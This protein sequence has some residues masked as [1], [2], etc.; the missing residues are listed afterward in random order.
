MIN[1]RRILQLAVVIGI[2]ALLVWRYGFDLRPPRSSGMGM[3]VTRTA[4]GFYSGTIQVDEVQVSTEYGGR[5]AEVIV[6]EG[7]AVRQG[8]VLAR[9]DTTLIDDQIA[10]AEAQLAVALAGLSQLQAGA[11]PGAVAIAEA[12]KA[13][14]EATRDAARQALADAQ[15]VQA[16]PQGLALQAT[17]ARAQLAAA[18]ARVEQAAAMRDAA[19][20]GVDEQGN[21]L[22]ISY[23][24]G[25]ASLPPLEV[26]LGSPE[27]YY[28]KSWA[29]VNGAAAARDGLREQVAQLEAQ[30]ADPQGPVARTHLAEAELARAEAAVAVAEAQVAGLKA[31]A[32]AEELAAVQARV[33]QA[34][35]ALDALKLQRE[36]MALTAP[37][38]G[39]VLARLA[40]PGEVAAPGAS[41]ITLGGLQQ[42]TLAVYVPESELGHVRP[43]QAARVTVDSFPGRVFDG[44]VLRIA[45][46]AEFT[47]RN[48]ATQEERVNT[49][50]VV[51]VR[52]P[53]AD[54]ALKPG[55]P[56]DA[57]L[58]EA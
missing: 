8:Q 37:I 31:G 18:E 5:V 30:L 22:L 6:E 46:R 4:T 3:T 47:P 32:R 21:P 49:Y 16:N 52:L 56:A 40:E 9:L 42:V 1:R 14:A 29:N 43:G 25:L 50:Y 12:E 38:D 45:D 55:M 57:V 36:R 58:E 24:L 34:A 26:K 44:R 54:G 11:R 15:A 48:V 17:V 28:W 13:Q 53:N 51:T 39:T 7:Q 19:S 23:S 35:A 33:G 10:I 41:L 27:V 2:V 20:V